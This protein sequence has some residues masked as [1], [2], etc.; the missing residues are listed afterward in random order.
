M[1][2]QNLR[3]GNTNDINEEL[4][5]SY[6]ATVEDDHNGVPN[7]AAN[8]KGASLNETLLS[9]HITAKPYSD[10]HGSENFHSPF[11]PPSK[12]FSSMV[13]CNRTTSHLCDST[14]HQ[15]LWYIK[16]HATISGPKTQTHVPAI[17]CNARHLLKL[18]Y[19]EIAKAMTD[20]VDPVDGSRPSNKPKGIDSTREES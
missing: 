10:T 5:R 14:Q 11:R 1:K 18:D 6:V 4:D 8:I 7:G 16:T 9:G 2:N 12:E 3:E 15:K 17:H 19:P 13:E 20:L